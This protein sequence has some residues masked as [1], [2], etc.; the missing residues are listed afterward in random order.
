LGELNIRKTELNVKKN[1]PSMITDWNQACLA[2]K[3]TRCFQEGVL[4]TPEGAD[5][6]FSLTLTP[7]SLAPSMTIEVEDYGLKASINDL[8]NAGNLDAHDPD[9]PTD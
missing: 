7:T 5:P 3:A 8:H 4:F 9:A 1:I 6:K 2:K